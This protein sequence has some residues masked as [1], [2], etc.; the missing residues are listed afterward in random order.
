MGTPLRARLPEL[1]LE[2]AMVVFAVL[3]ALAF[4]EWREN[5]H[6][7]E[8]AD[9]ART[10]VV[11]EATANLEELE[12]TSADLRSVR[13]RLVQAI[14]SMEEGLDTSLDLT[15]ELPEF[16]SAAW[17]AAQV[18]QAAPYLDYAW[19][20]RVSRAYENVRVSAQVQAQLLETLGGLTAAAS[21]RDTLARLS[22]QVAMLL[23]IHETLEERF[24]EIVAEG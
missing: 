24:R 18:T 12:R 2:A 1:A 17:Q 23:Q 11:A 10:A 16:S 19:V 15:F 22:V 5:R 8:L 13:E 3:V 14:S 4:D 6:F 21:E 9:R 7:R 20:I